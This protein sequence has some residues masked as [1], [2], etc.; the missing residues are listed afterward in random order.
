MA[1]T[2]TECKQVRMHLYQQTEHLV[3]DLLK[4][5]QPFNMVYSNMYP[6]ETW[7]SF[8]GAQH[9]FDQIHLT[10]P[11]DLGL[12][13]DALN[14]TDCSQTRCHVPRSEIGWGMTR[15]TA[16]KYSHDYTTPVFCLDTMRDMDHAVEYIGAIV[17]GLKKMPDLIISAFN[18]RHAMLQ[19]GD[20]D[21]K[22]YIGDNR[23]IALEVVSAAA[24]D[25]AFFAAN[26]DLNLGGAGNLPLSK[27]KIE[28]LNNHVN[29]LRMNGYHQ[30]EY[31]PKGKFQIVL[32]D[33]TAQ[34]LTVQNPTLAGKYA[35]ADFEKGGA[36]FEYGFMDGIGNW[37]FKQNPECARYK[38]IGAGV[39]R[40]VLPFE[41][42]D[43]SKGLKPVF[44]DYYDEAEYQFYHVY[45]RSSK[46]MHVGD[47][48]SVNP[49]MKFGMNRDLKGQW[50]F[51]TPDVI[52]YTDPNSGTVCTIPND[53][54][55]QGYF[56][57][58]FE[59]GIKTKRVNTEMWILCLRENAVIGDNVTLATAATDWDGSVAYQD[60][61]A[62]NDHCPVED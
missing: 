32:D 37:M 55:N 36:F 57:G 15:R 28:F 48:T 43:A 22:I 47:V 51:K 11:N 31:N 62:Y 2:A 58:E 38:H 46:T 23:K 50:S 5:I 59:L 24:A 30:G 54:H 10:R 53:K 26:G 60:L 56:L 12:W 1:I 16:K 52:Y 21:A 19:D 33:Q 45:D 44:S 25:H 7:K 14:V 61:K 40:P 41:N 35:F 3:D 49:E 42:K 17:D 6:V 8:T 13:G 18:M 9:E 27:L 39:L 34:D 4:D 29:R 20:T